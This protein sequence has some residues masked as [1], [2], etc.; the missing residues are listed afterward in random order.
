MLILLNLNVVL[1]LQL[2]TNRKLEM[3][4]LKGPTSSK[5]QSHDGALK[6][7][8]QRLRKKSKGKDS[9]LAII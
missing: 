8:H 9:S 2:P 1:L 7:F 3:L 6:V 5:G 4:S